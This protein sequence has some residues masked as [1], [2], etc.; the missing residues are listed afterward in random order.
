MVFAYT[1]IDAMLPLTL[2]AGPTEGQGPDLGRL[3]LK[4][5]R[6]VGREGVGLQLGDLFFAQ[7]EPVFARTSSEPRSLGKRH[8]AA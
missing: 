7:E 3:V 1:A 2:A 4:D 6:H 8:F 5:L